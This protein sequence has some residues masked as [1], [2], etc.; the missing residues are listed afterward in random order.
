MVITKKRIVNVDNVL[1]EF[2]ENEEV[3]IILYDAQKFEKI[4]FEI[5]FET[6]DL[7]ET[8][9]PTP[10]GSVSRYNADGKYEILK[11]LPK[12][13][14]T[15]TM[16]ILA[17]GKYD[18][19]VIFTRQR[20]QRRLI[21]APSIE[22]TIS[23]DNDGKKIISSPLIKITQ[24][25]KSSIKHTINLFLEIF[26]ECQIVD[27][28]LISRVK[29]PTKR[30]NW[31]LLPKGKMNWEKLEKHLDESIKKKPTKTRKDIYARINY[32]NSFEPDFIAMGNAGF[33]DYVVL[34]FEE[35]NLYILEN[36]KPQNATYIFEDNWKNLTQLSKGE[37]LSENLQKGRLLHTSSWRENIKKVI[38]EVDK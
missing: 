2:T 5:G 12:E 1:T 30:L 34:G 6:L 32:I 13:S 14:Y 27:K 29:T 7:G 20:Y 4:L 35:K 28:N 16:D 15:I 33:N 38:L 26:K 18:T 37:I 10:M 9:L 24:E 17:F 11:D 3:L 36:H 25:N 23:L 19:T 22:I 31:N 21:D 8:I